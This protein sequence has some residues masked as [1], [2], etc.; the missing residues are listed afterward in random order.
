MDSLKSEVPQ[1]THAEAKKIYINQYHEI[2]EP[3]LAIKSIDYCKQSPN[4]I[5]EELK[6]AIKKLNSKDKDDPSCI[7]GCM[8]KDEDIVWTDENPLHQLVSQ[9]EDQ[10]EIARFQISK[11]PS[12]GGLNIKISSKDKDR[13]LKLTTFVLD[14]EDQN[15]KG[16]ISCLEAQPNYEFG[17]IYEGSID[18][19]R[20]KHRT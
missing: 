6:E 10:S 8:M 4:I 12:S 5:S 2:S 13:A 14:H 7:I 19:F 3:A 11:S 9:N 15:L 20:N 16:F 1:T 17:T 18:G